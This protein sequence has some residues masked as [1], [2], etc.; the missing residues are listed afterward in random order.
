MLGIVAL[1]EKM[2]DMT[3]WE[4]PELKPSFHLIIALLNKRKLL[5]DVAFLEKIVYTT[6]G[7]WSLCFALSSP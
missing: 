2:V 1:L 4:L 6:N 7:N 3:N 5:G